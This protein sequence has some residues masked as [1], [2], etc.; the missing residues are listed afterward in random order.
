MCDLRTHTPLLTFLT[1]VTDI[2]LDL[3]Q[4]FL[5]IL[6]LSVEN[7]EACAAAEGCQ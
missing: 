5:A 1:L 3:F 6:R 7:L 4:L 2:L